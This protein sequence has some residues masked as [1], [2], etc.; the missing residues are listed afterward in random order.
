MIYIT[1][2]IED[3][4]FEKAIVGDCLRSFSGDSEDRMSAEVLLVWHFS[5]NEVSLADFPKVKAIVRYGVGFD[6]IDL[7]FCKSRGI[8]VFNNPDYGVD[9][10]SDTALAMIMNFSRCINAYNNQ[11]RELVS[12]PDPLKPWQENTNKNA[13]RLKDAN[14]GLVGV[15][16]IG[17]ALA[18]KMKNIIG[19]INF[20]DP[21][22]VAGYEKVLGANR[23][24]SL[25]GLLECSD[26]VSVHT[27]LGPET[28][29]LI[30]DAFVNSM[31]DGCILINSARGGLLSSKACIYNGLKSGKIGAVG[32]D[33]LPEEPPLLDAKD[34]FLSSW[35]DTNNEFS[36][37]IMIN[38]HTAYYSPQS[39]E[40]MRRK[41]ATMALKALQDQQIQNRII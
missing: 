9:E 19:S 29:E 34:E 1:D 12:S 17:S 40:E 8:K 33:V 16:R 36:D 2:Y 35:L 22:V 15:G 23:Y 5:V 6:N 38:P 11:S 25:E 7:D 4:D 41:A 28:K 20:Y 27:P 18:L 39:Y 32:L 31:K 26:I 10:V 37:R 13:L 3:P 21:Y 30:D 24:D 14:L